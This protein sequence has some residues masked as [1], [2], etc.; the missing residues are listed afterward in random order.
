MGKTS[1]EP[2][3]LLLMSDLTLAASFSNSVGSMEDSLDSKY[4]IA[5][6]M[7]ILFLFVV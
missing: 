3:A 4:C 5:V 1:S 2:N 6:V 7:F